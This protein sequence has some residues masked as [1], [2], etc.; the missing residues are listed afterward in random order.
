MPDGEFGEAAG[1][2]A[3]FVG[4]SVALAVG[5]GSSGFVSALNEQGDGG[6]L[7]VGLGVVGGLSAAQPG[8][9][10]TGVSGVAGLSRMLACSPG[11][12]RTP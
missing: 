11:S 2:V 4:R 3:F 7:K 1:E 12:P 8:E 9:C 10:Q 5:Q 6:E